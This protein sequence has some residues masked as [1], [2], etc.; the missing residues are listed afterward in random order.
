MD[1]KKTVEEALAKPMSRKEFLARAG[2]VT[3]ALVG[4][5]AALKSL[6]ESTSGRR[7]GTYGSSVYGG[8]RKS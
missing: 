3:L 4:I 1:V 5:T 7:P 8:R 2:S 6:R